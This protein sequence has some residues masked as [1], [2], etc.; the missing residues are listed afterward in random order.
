MLHGMVE[1]IVIRSWAK[2]FTLDTLDPSFV[3]SAKWDQS[4]P[5]QIQQDRLVNFATYLHSLGSHSTFSFSIRTGRQTRR[6]RPLLDEPFLF[7]LPFPPPVPELP[8]GYNCQRWT[9]GKTQC[10]FDAS[11][12]LISF[13]Q[14]SC[15]CLPVSLTVT[16]ALQCFTHI[17]IQCMPIY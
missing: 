7:P 8:T 12:V 4:W 5:I 17:H 13:L 3:H 2:M 9:L 11:C 15:K 1:L 14:D 16:I 10:V 6:G